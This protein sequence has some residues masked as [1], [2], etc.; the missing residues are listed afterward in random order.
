MSAHI[1]FV[2]RTLGMVPH[3]RRKQHI[4]LTLMIRHEDTRSSSHSLPS[5]SSK[6]LLSIYAQLQTN[7]R[8]GGVPLEVGGGILCEIMTAENVEERMREK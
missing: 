3:P 8:R 2:N 6:M 4:Q 7:N 5:M 1:N